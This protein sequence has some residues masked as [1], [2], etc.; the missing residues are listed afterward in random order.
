MRDNDLR[1]IV[2]EQFYRRRHEDERCGLDEIVVG[3][4]LPGEL[5]R[6]GNVCEQLSQYNLIEW[7]AI[8]GVSGSIA[9]MGRITAT[10]VDVI[11][12][13]A[14]APISLTVHDHSVSVSGSSNFQIGNSN[15]QAFNTTIEKLVSAI[16]HSSASIGEKSEAKSLLQKL[17]DNKLII[18]ALG[19]LL[20]GLGSAPVN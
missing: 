4:G 20:S 15:S 8:K 13:T 2:L 17:A 19:T 1:G 18:A 9:G 5:Q 11:E 7:N 12:G 14:R 16:D 10:G 6:V 3:A